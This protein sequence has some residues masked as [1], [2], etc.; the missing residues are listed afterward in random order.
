MPL[1]QGAGFRTR[2]FCPPVIRCQRWRRET[3]GGGGGKREE[4]L[5][6]RGRVKFG[7]SC[8]RRATGVRGKLIYRDLCSSEDSWEEAHAGDVLAEGGQLP[9]SG[10]LGASACFHMQIVNTAVPAALA[11]AFSISVSDT[12]RRH[13]Y[14]RA[15][16]TWSGVEQPS[17]LRMTAFPHS[18]KNRPTE[19]TGRIWGPS[20]KVSLRFTDRTPSAAG[21]ARGN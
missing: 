12:C 3:E 10:E 8:Q 14:R 11:F 6:G 4:R 16:C 2:Y 1:H 20:I 9:R 19:R 13:I 5:R 17:S 18:P 15:H 7:K 21:S